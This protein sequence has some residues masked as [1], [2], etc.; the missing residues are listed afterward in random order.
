MKVKSKLSIKKLLRSA[1]ENKVSEI[2]R[3]PNKMSERKTY[4]RKYLEK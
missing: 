4:K 3:M 1:L 2:S